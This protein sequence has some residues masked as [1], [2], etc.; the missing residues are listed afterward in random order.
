L[1]SRRLWRRSWRSRRPRKSRPWR[2]KFGQ[3]N[4]HIFL[5]DC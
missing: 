5:E 2:L 1:K 4:E 3:Q